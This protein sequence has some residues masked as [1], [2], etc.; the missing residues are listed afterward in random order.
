M[1]KQMAVRN[2]EVIIG[3]GYRAEEVLE[4]VDFEGLAR[5]A[6]ESEGKPATSEVSI[7]FVDDERMQELN[8]EF[9]G[10]DRPTDVLSFECDNLDDGFVVPSGDEA[11]YELGDIVIAPDVAERQ[12]PE[13]GLTFADEL[14][15][16]TVHGILHLC[17]HDHMNE[18]EAQEME[19]RETAILSEFYGRPFRREAE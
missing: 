17:G 15:L 11:P 9:R 13:Y 3:E 5:F 8:C 6:I 2:V 18:E 4:I 19:G 12:A 1:R 16:L 10:L 14:S 7:S